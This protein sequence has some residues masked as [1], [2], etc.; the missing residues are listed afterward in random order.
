[1]AAMQP[2]PFRDSQKLSRLFDGI[3]AIGPLNGSGVDLSRG[4]ATETLREALHSP[5]TTLLIEERRIGGEAGDRSTEWVGAGLNCGAAVLTAMAASASIGGTVITFGAMSPLAALTTAGAAAGA[6]QC[7]GSLTRLANAY[8]DNVVFNP[9]SNA[10]LDSDEGWADLNYMLDVMGLVSGVA[11]G[12][13]AAPKYA[14]LAKYAKN[15]KA[16]AALPRAERKVVMRQLAKEID[17][18]SK[19][20][21]FREW[22]A[23][24]GVKSSFST[25]ALT[26]IA[27]HQL[28][29]ELATFLGVTG[30]ALAA[31]RGEKSA[32]GDFVD[33]SKIEAQAAGDAIRYVLHITQTP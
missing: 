5:A 33:G 31:S 23:A 18:V 25:G 32:V 12:L 30:S 20:K 17:E 15:S 13:A 27:R 7:G 29:N 11:G 4:G 28:M 22:I 2:D 1:M 14:S 9:T 26:T 3:D 8:G 16:L 19:S 24:Q 6:F 21:V 10:Y